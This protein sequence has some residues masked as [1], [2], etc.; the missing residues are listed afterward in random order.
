MESKKKRLL[1]NTYHLFFDAGTKNVSSRPLQEFVDGQVIGFGTAI[2]EKLR[3]IR[4]F[5][6]LLQFQSRQMKGLVLHWK[7]IPFS[8]Q[9]TPDENTA[10]YADDL[11]LTIGSGKEKVTM[12]MRFSI[13]LHF[14][15]RVWKVIHWHGSKPEEVKSKEDTYGVDQWKKRASELQQLV[16]QR[17]ADLLLKNRELAIEASLEKVRAVAMGMKERSDMLKICT[18]IAKQLAVLG[19]SEIRNV[20]TAIFKV[21]AGTYMNYEYY[22]KH[23]KTFITETLYTN[24]KLAFAFAKKM[25]KGKGAVS[26]THIKGKEKVMDWLRYQKGTNVFI[27]SFLK[28]TTSL[29]YYWYSL[30]PVALGTST[31][32]P[33]S[34]DELQLF[35]RFLKVFELAYQRYL[36]I[37]KAEAQA[38][39]AQ[40]EAALERVRARS[41]AMNDSTEIGKLILHVYTE[42]TKL[43]T[44]LDRCFF[45]IVNPANRGITWWMASQEGLLSANG[46]FVQY[47]EHPSHQLYLNHWKKRTK[48]W[49]YL[50]AGKEKR[51]WDRFGFSKTE[52]TRLPEPVKKF[53]AGA[54]SVHLSGSS[55]AFGSLV[56]G[57]FEPLS[58]EHQDILSRFASV[59]NQTYTR[60]ND[61]KKAE[62]QAREAQIEAALERVRSRSLA[63]H[64]SDELKDVIR[65]V[66]AEIRKLD[67]LAEHAGFYMDYKMHD[68][69]HIWLADPNIEPFYAVIPYFDTPTWNS[70]LEA[71]ATGRTLHSD[72][73]D[74][75]AKNK[76][77]QS[78]FKLF[79][80]PE[81]ARKFYLQCKGLAVST[82]LLDNVG[83]YIENF[84]AI[85]YTDE[86]NSILMRFGKVFQQTYTRFLDLQKAEEQ[87]RES[88]IQLAL[89]R[90][91]A[92]TM[93]MQHS[94]ELPEAAN[95]LFQQMQA[96]GMPAWS[97]GYCIWKDDKKAV[98]LWMSSE[99]VLQPPFEAPTTEDE[100]FIEMRRG[101]EQGKSLHVIEMGGQKL[102]AHYAY[103][104]TLPVVGEI[105]DSILEA[106]HPLPAYQVMHYAYFSKGYLLFITYEPVPQAHPVFIRFASVFD[107]TYT[108]FLDLKRAEEQ[109]RE[110][111]IEVAVERV[112]AKALAMHRS[113]DLHSVVI[114]LK[115]ELQ[116]LKIPNISAATI[117][118]EQE[119]GLI[120]VL[121]L[122][123]AGKE[124]DDRPQ[125]QLDAVF[126]LED[127]DPKLWVRRMWA[128]Q[129]KYFVHEADQEDFLRVIEFLHGI[130]P[131]AGQQA[132]DII[133][134]DS[135]WK[136]WL[137]TVKLNNGVMNIDLLAPPAAE[138]ENIMIKIGAGFD[139]AYKR[140]QDLLKAEAQAREAQI[141]AALEKVRSRSLAMHDSREIKEVV[142]TVFVKMK[143][144]GFFQNNSVM[145]IF[146]KNDF[147]DF[148]HWT[149]N[150]N[151]ET[152]EYE[153]PAFDHPVST[154][155]SEA[156]KKGDPHFEIYL[157]RKGKDVFLD[158]I[159]SKTDYAKVPDNFKQVLYDSDAY[160]QFLAFEE[161][162]GL[163]VDTFTSITYTQ[164]QK[165]VV[166][167][168]AKVFDQAYVRFQDLQKAEALAR[169]AHIEAALER[170]R[171]KTMAMH[172]SEDVADTVD[173][174]FNELIKLEIRPMRCGLAIIHQD[175]NMEVWSARPNEEGKASLV[176]GKLSTD[177]HPLLKG[178]YENWKK[179]KESYAYVL[180][181]GDV[182]RYFTA[183]NNAPDYPIRYE[184]ASLP[185][186]IYHHEF[187]FAEGS[188]FTFSVEP[189]STETAQVLKRFAAVFGQTYRRYL[190]LQKAEAQTREAQ[191]EAALERI[192][193]KVTSMKESSDLQDI[194]VYMRSEFVALD[195]EAGYFWYMRWLPEKYQKV[196]T[197]GDG[198]RIGMVMELPRHI[199]GDIPLIADWEKGT[200]PSIVYP[201]DV[202]AAVDYVDKMIRLGDFEQVDPQAPTLDDIRHIGGLTFV[203]ARTTHGEIGF[204]LVGPVPDPPPE[205][206]NTLVRFAAVFDLAYQRFEDLK[207]AEANNRETQIELALEKVRSR[208]M[209]MQNSNELQETAAVL[210]Q[211]FRKL[212]A[213][214]MYQVTIGIYDEESQL[215]D[216]R[217]TSW[218]GSGEQENKSFQLDMNEPTVLKP[219]IQ[220][221]KNQQK[222]VVI[223]LS[224]V[225]L[226]G[227]LQYRNK[228][229]G[230]TV[231]SADTG[232]RRVI[233]VAFYSKGHLSISTREPVSA[234][235]LRTLE[236]FAAVFDATYT[237]FQ[238]LQKAEAQ[239]KE[240]RIEA[241]LERVRSRTL[242]MQKSDELAETAAVLFQQLIALGIEPNRL[243]IIL[244]KENTSEMEAW[245]TDEDGSKV[246]MAFT[247]NY[248][249][250]QSL[251]KMYEGWKEKRTSLVIDMQG[252]ELQEYFHYLHNELH[253]PFR[254]GLEQKRRVQHIVY[255]SHGLIGMASPDEQPAENMQLMERFAAVFNL[256]FTRFNDLKIAEAHAAQAEKDLVA[257]KEA[258]QKAE[259]A[260]TELQATQKQLIQSE[261]MASLGELTAGIAHEIQNPL[262][263]VNNFSEV[264]KELLD[265][266]KEELDKGNLEEARAIMQDV[267]Q[268]L[269]KIH[270]HGKRADGIVKGM[271]QHS[272]T[273]SG[274]MEPTDINA[275]CDEYLRLS[276]HGLRAKD[277]SFNS[278]FE[279]DFDPA[280]G[281]VNVLPQDLG[282]V[283]LNLIN[284]AFY[285]VTERKKKS[286]T[287]YDPIVSISTRQE[288]GT[289]LINVK[290][291][292]M[293]IPRQVLD[294]IFQPF[295]TTK[296]TGQGTGLGLSLSYDIVKAHGG[297]IVVETTE[298][299]G[300]SFRIQLP[301]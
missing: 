295:F 157:D 253:V 210:F 131:A 178:A 23:D 266:I 62:A 144:L 158:Q 148:T 101:H 289:I 242:A 113:E 153:I 46:F 287:G 271:L 18:I 197:S 28:K 294:K 26:I 105:F 293:G 258:K 198:S 191:I 10:V 86:E 123:D 274:Q 273:G 202:D 110:A 189:I 200:E 4:D 193:G 223:D 280:V 265:E 127:T 284:N 241:A 64:Q 2:D 209:A 199:H 166:T 87:T 134:G 119:D 256:T 260:L 61:L 173:T 136:A 33:L 245:V 213:E 133:R 55:D 234:E 174:L 121:D 92:R 83:L 71:K 34:K 207:L 96:L 250:N 75:K 272:R 184:L 72:L 204:S 82:V 112:R 8:R 35:E 3:G 218:S 239:A 190:D 201:M 179:K 138:I 298:G 169:E 41:M 13:V 238:D 128:Q 57:S 79:N 263:F 137:P 60:F 183:I 5:R 220:A 279:T 277:K 120:R 89:E 261:K 194:V 95:L 227:W 74:F 77:Y 203:M 160:S 186:T 117:Y 156:W 7:K 56:T 164:E 262:N 254:G 282:R 291:N 215:I 172:S 145:I 269:E 151:F 12:Y 104:R 76:F 31:Y 115:K 63:M 47:N 301:V 222:S 165:S 118:L 231:S 211:E 217:V 299:E 259:E 141:E 267:I 39:E 161:H 181:D 229:S 114:T 268:N 283:I 44:R 143:D 94:A 109:A 17:T 246:S 25:L 42:L 108:R 84:S 257:I 93:A 22:A 54:K 146:P 243:Y 20:Q 212:G 270:H 230:I 240:A 103:M 170:V 106:G 135:I 205:S 36:D 159:F 90:V 67:I 224:G 24:H 97:A 129:E 14:N 236:R 244:I 248:N 219:A 216:F 167:R 99:G 228:M 286:E 6:K 192:R 150:E 147:R 296:P 15:G 80:V 208:T 235:T 16:E 175:K 275:L 255:F 177:I 225:A 124:D 206:I 221:W 188:L 19:L 237:R 249:K 139:L 195:H 142:K 73:L 125:F 91:R 185:G 69:M 300:T 68:D 132:E 52:L 232:G 29:S 290:D 37:E 122:S 50:F 58:D 21:P 45:M 163:L 247:G 59:F 40:I 152:M 281:K 51:D 162:C 27:D 38:R 116:G 252:A 49:Q 168:F 278:K 126:R 297:E 233:T 88:Q 155:A 111:Q 98:T 176:V 182:E 264:S 107:Q 226:E 292:G 154:W 180:K 53:M 1:E 11:Y 65:L 43:D 214:D 100:L 140:F 85:P 285:A 9:I 32:Q 149:F 196:M 102:N 251:F 78:L 48:K 30:G 81:E 70:F 66:L 171:S 276:Y 130:D 288:N 187:G